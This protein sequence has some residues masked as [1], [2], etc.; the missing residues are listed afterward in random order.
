MATD[1]SKGQFALFDEPHLSE[2]G[3]K[4]EF[5]P[6]EHWNAEAVQHA[7]DELFNLARKYRSSK[8][9][10]QLINFVIR[11]HFYSPYNAMLIHIQ[12]P[13]ATFVAPAH[14]WVQQYGRIVKPNAH[15]LVILRPM[16]PVMFVFDI[17]DT[18]P[19]PNA[20]PLPPEVVKPFEV[21]SGRL[22]NQLELTIENAKRDGV[23]ILLQK[24]GSQSAGSICKKNGKSLPSPLFF[25]T[26]TDKEGKPIYATIL[27]RYSLIL[28]E[29]LSKEAQYATMIHELA[30]LYCG[31]LGTPNKN[32]WP[33]RRGL[34]KEVCEFEAESTS[35]L[36]CRRLGIDSPSDEYLASYLSRHEDVPSI[37]L[38]CIMKA[39]GLIEKMGQIRLKLRKSRE[40]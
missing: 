13:G 18:E 6:A 16:G 27:V 29:N 24:H 10:R 22:T 5:T 30:H 11:F 19:G 15:P 32:W 33:D 25:R 20:K 14:R 37:S 23:Q 2:H 21:R 3:Q 9:Y 35:Y 12:M 28:N 26:G 39:A 36:I 40:E 34:S 17:A 1:L 4:D 8:S 31:H 38:E 7:L